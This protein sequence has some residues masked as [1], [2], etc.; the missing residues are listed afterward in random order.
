MFFFLFIICIVERS[1]IMRELSIKCIIN[2]MDIVLVIG[3]DGEGKVNIDIGV[4]FLNY[5][6]DLF[7]KYG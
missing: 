4:F 5:M 7:I 3:I 6:F 1:F 2:E